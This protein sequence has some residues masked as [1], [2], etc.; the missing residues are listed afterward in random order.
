MVITTAC[1]F[2]S[3]KHSGV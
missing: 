3:P 1:F 2:F